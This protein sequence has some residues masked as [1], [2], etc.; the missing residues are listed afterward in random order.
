MSTYITEKRIARQ[1]WYETGTTKTGW[2]SH[3]WHFLEDGLPVGE[4]WEIEEVLE[5]DKYYNPVLAL[6]TK[7]TK[8]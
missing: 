3:G 4:D 8:Y 5:N 7:E 6:F 1:D 2:E